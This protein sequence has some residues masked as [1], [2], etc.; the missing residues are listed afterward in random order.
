MDDKPSRQAFSKRHAPIDIDKYVQIAVLE[1]RKA[2]ASFRGDVSR[3][4][5]KAINRI[6]AAVQRRSRSR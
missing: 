1:R 5:G 4:L 3:W 2:I 6:A